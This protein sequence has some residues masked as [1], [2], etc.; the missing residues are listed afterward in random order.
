VT[1]HIITKAI[2]VKPESE[3]IFS[4]MATTVSLDDEGAGMFVIVSQHGR[5]DMGKIVI[6]PGEWP[7]LRAA[8]DQMMSACK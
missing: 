8:I 4:E 2:L 3:P 5:L 7:M 6:D 1:Y